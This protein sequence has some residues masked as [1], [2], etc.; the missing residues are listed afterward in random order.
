MISNMT[1]AEWVAHLET[2]LEQQPHNVGI[3]FNLRDVR[4]MNAKQ[5]A[6]HKAKAS[7]RNAARDVAI[8]KM[9]EQLMGK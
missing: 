7:E 4:A 2:R 8:A 6:A 9:A 5:W 3:K 1:Q